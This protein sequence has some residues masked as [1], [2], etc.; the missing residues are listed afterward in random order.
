MAS[1]FSRLP[2]RR[3]AKQVATSREPMRTAQPN[4]LQPMPSKRYAQQ[5]HISTPARLESIRTG[6]SERI[7]RTSC[8]YACFCGG[9]LG[10]GGSHV[11][12]T[13]RQRSRALPPPTLPRPRHSSCARRRAEGLTAAE[14][15]QRLYSFLGECAARLAPASHSSIRFALPCQAEAALE[16]SRPLSPF[17]RKS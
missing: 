12:C 8:T 17:S 2:D 16:P 5:L 6:E 3:I 11:H 7:M 4:A 10:C 9:R 1:P 13:Q 15:L 14:P